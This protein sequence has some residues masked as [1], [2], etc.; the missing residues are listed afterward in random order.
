MAQ[1]YC[2]DDSDRDWLTSLIESFERAEMEEAEHRPCDRE[3]L[4]AAKAHLARPLPPE[5]KQELPV[6]LVS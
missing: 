6:R 5:A 1:H 4:R 3:L 2:H